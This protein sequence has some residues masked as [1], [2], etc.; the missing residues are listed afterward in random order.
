MLPTM[1]QAVRLI[2]HGGLDR[3][4]YGEVPMPSPAGAEVLVKV[5][6]CGINNTDINT[7]TAW[8]SDAVEDAVGDGAAS[9]FQDAREADGSWGAGGIVFPRI[10]GA[11]VAGRIVA[12]G[13]N[14]D[15]NRIGQRVL[16][17]PW[18]LSHGEWLDAGTAQYL[19]S[20]I[21]GGYAEYTS[22]RAANAVPICSDLSDAELATFPCAYTTAESL[23]HATLPRPGETVVITGAS[24]GVGS[25]AV[26]LASRR[27]CRVIAV[28]SIAKASQL[29][30]LGAETVIDR[31]TGDLLVAILNAAGGPVDIALDV[32]GAPMFSALIEALGQGGRYAS[33][34]C[35]GGPL[36]SIDLRKLIYKDLSLRGITICPPGTMQRVVRMIES[37]AIRPLLAASF[38]LAEIRAAQEVFVAKHHVGNIVVIP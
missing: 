3:L 5:G 2:G 22:V 32:V 9:G 17:D 11:D 34:G 7:R 1:M 4:V 25:A 33:S 24:G 36:A 35:I 14:V 15:S 18:L 26:Q 30:E 37:G 28:A 16:V 6:A 8:Y 27:G 19:G 12:V 31:D 29:L 10:Q 13:E 20:E 38:P 21:D 23:V